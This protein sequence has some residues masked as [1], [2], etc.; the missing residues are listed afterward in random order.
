MFFF[1]WLTETLHALDQGAAEQWNKRSVNNIN[2]Y[3]P[4]PDTKHLQNMKHLKQVWGKASEK[5]INW[6]WIVNIS[7]SKFLDCFSSDAGGEVRVL[8]RNSRIR[9][10]ELW[11][12]RVLLFLLC[13]INSGNIEQTLLWNSLF[14][15]LPC[16]FWTGRWDSSRLTLLIT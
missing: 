10:S 9:S 4:R 3:K 6:K 15:W 11:S 8:I 16:S 1:S 14:P 2:A 5:R 7:K 12:S 13:A